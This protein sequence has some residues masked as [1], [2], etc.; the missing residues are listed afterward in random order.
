[1]TIMTDLNIN[2][3]SGFSPMT[4]EMIDSGNIFA[5]YKCSQNIINKNM[6]EVSHRLSQQKNYNEIKRMIDEI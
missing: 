3:N 2:S 6:A 4:N 5:H 1:M